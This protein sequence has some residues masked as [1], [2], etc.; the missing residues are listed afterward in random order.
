LTGSLIRATS[1]RRFVKR[2]LSVSSS[3]VPGRVDSG[4]CRSLGEPATGSGP[5]HTWHFANAGQYPF[6]SRM[7]DVAGSDSSNFAFVIDPT[8]MATVAT[9]S[10]TLLSRNVAGDF[11]VWLELN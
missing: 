11:P 2:S 4:V 1:C 6:W 8:E 3:D 10:W 7:I 5:M 9:L